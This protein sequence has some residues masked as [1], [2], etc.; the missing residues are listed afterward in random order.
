MSDSIHTLGH[1]IRV[2]KSISLIRQRLLK[3]KD[4][5]IHIRIK[6]LSGLVQSLIHTDTEELGKVLVPIAWAEVTLRRQI[7]D[8]KGAAETLFVMGACF[9]DMGRLDSAT[10][11]CRMGTEISH[12]G[13][14]IDEEMIG[15]LCL[16]LLLEYQSR[17]EEALEAVEQAMRQF[18]DQQ[19]SWVWPQYLD[20]AKEINQTLSN[21]PEA[22]RSA[23]C[24]ANLPCDSIETK[25]DRIRTLAQLHH[26]AG[27]AQEAV[28]LILQAGV[29]YLVAGLMEKAEAS[30]IEFWRWT[31]KKAAKRGRLKPRPSGNRGH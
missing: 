1:A 25:A 3:V 31:E 16:A 26:Q 14:H 23:K 19:D 10:R 8:L 17:H 21:M 15:R 28:Q 4:S 5:P 7:G 6:T 24:I 9:K 18:Q 20:L 30:R 12:R 29:K 13:G 22:I 27:Y 11:T 2:E